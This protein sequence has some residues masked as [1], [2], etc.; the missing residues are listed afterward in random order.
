LYGCETW[1]LTLRE[2][3]RLRV[4]EN[5]VLRKIFGAKRDEV[6]GEWRKL[7]NIEL[8]A[9]YSSPDIIRNI[10]SRRLRWAGHVARMSESKNAYRVLVG[11]PE[12]KRPLE[13]PRRRWEDN[14]K[15]DLRKVEY[16][17][18]DWINL[19]QDRDQWRAYVR[20][21]FLD[22]DDDGDGDDDDD[23]DDVYDDFS[24]ESL[25]A[26]GMATTS[27]TEGSAKDRSHCDDVARHLDGIDIFRGRKTLFRGDP[28]V[29]FG[30]FFKYTSILTCL[31]NYECNIST[32]ETAVATNSSPPT[33]E[34]PKY[35]TINQSGKI[36]QTTQLAIR[37]PPDGTGGDPNRTKPEG[38]NRR[39][40]IIAFKPP[41]LEGYI[42]DPTVRFESHEHQPEEVHEEKRNIY[43][44]SISFYKDKYHLESIV[45]TGLMIGARGTIPRDSLPELF[46]HEPQ[47]P[48]L[49]K[50]RRGD[51]ISPYGQSRRPFSELLFFSTIITQWPEGRRKP[52]PIPAISQFVMCHQVNIP[53]RAQKY[54]SNKRQINVLMSCL[55]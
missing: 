6:T 11:R 17:D 40:D 53:P 12:G 52:L 32:V 9:L 41:S 55:P 13:R 44:P 31:N 33:D 43:E 16:N 54:A 51:Y 21:A 29:R 39:I 5:E 23:D 45:I 42:I 22:D 24:L 25:A 49:A 1:T 48:A 19:A 18:R 35:G 8:H 4:F 3:Q 30:A 50:D 7:H 34:E 38:S 2:E 26:A 37:R 36:C 20:T 47:E 28:G 10:K 15:M 27:S 46:G 14:I